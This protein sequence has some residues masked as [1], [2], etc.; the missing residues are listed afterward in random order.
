MSDIILNLISEVIAKADIKEPNRHKELKLKYMCYERVSELI[1]DYFL[2]LQNDSETLSSFDVFQIS[3]LLQLD[4]ADQNNLENWVGLAISKDFETVNTIISETTAQNNMI[5]SDPN[6]ET[7]RNSGIIDEEKELMHSL[8]VKH[9]EYSNA[10]LEE[11]GYI[12]DALLSAVGKNGDRDLF[13]S[14]IEFYRK[15]AISMDLK[16]RLHKNNFLR[17]RFSPEITD[18]IENV[19]S[20]LANEFAILE[21]KHAEIVAKLRVYAMSGPEF[22]SIASQYIRVTRMINQ[23]SL[24]IS[25]FEKS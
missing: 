19:K 16:L 6:K 18:A 20:S 3:R 17:S 24:D 10:L 1:Q 5:T 7:Q 13:T 23:L 21:K 8:V 11:L 25:N 22:E 2:S 15:L 4:V 14:I 9:I 12:Q